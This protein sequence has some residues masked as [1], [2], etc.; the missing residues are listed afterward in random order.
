MAVGTTGRVTSNQAARRLSAFCGAGRHGPMPL[1]SAVLTSAGRL[2]YKAIIH[3][4]GISMWWVSSQRSIQR[5]VVSAMELVNQHGFASVAFPV[6]GGG[7]GGTQADRALTWML[8]SL[9]RVESNAAVT[10]VQYSRR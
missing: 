9:E 4:A 1:G 7:T 8:Q 2:P 10:V 6:I 5:S 3:V